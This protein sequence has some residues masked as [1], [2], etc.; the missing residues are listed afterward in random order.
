MAAVQ[1]SFALSHQNQAVDSYRTC[2]WVVQVSVAGALS[3]VV[4]LMC[5]VSGV[6]LVSVM[7]MQTRQVA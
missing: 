5:G 4:S 6:S 2:M 3:V 7:S 1:R